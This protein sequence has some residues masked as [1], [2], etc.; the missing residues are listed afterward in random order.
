MYG[1]LSVI[2][3]LSCRGSSCG[4]SLWN[5]GISMHESLQIAMVRT[6]AAV[7]T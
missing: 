1:G 6:E 2:E 5:F 4:V 7:Y 3:S